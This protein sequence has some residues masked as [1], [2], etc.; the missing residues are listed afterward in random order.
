MKKKPYLNM[1]VPIQFVSL[2]K[3]GGWYYR[4]NHKK[5]PLI[6]ISADL[7]L[8]HKIRLLFHEFTH[9]IVDYLSDINNA[10]LIKDTK[11]IN[12]NAKVIQLNNITDK[13]EEIL[14]EKIGVF[15]KNCFYNEFIYKKV[16]PLKNEKKK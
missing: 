16:K 3:S 4:H 5:G 13:R 8:F 11:K 2:T 10:R 12:E 7:E 14:A 6:Q 15:A 9:E 1:K